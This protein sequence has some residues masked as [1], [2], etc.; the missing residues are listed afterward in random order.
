MWLKLL[1]SV[2]LVIFCTFLGYLAAGKYRAR[3]KFFAQ[4]TA[5]NDLYLNELTYSRR[6][7][8]ELIAETRESGDFF[9]VLQRRK[10]GPEIR[11]QYLS[12]EE[13]KECADYFKMLG[14]GDS[15]SQKNYFSAKK[16]ALESKKAESEKVAAERGGLY[17]KLGL[18]A[19]LAFVILIV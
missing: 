14:A 18:L 16:Q 11:L 5:F 17:L 6:T 3:K 10:D 9:D 4:M 1:I 12:A 7:L 2:G 13:K 8:K 15:F 19:G